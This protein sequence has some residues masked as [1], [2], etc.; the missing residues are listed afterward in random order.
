MTLPPS[1]AS[2]RL[3]V[4]DGALA[5]ITR[6]PLSGSQR[7]YVEGVLHPQ[8]KVPMR[9][10]S[11]SPTHH[12]NGSHTPNPPVVV[13]DTSG[14]YTDPACA[15]DLR[16]GL[17]PLRARWIEGRGDVERLPGLS[18][19]YGVARLADRRLDALR[20][21]HL[22]SPLRAKASGNVSQLHYAR[23][24]M[25][26]PEMEYVAIRESQRLE[27]AYQGQHAGESYG[28]QIGAPI[29]PEFVRDEIARGRAIIPANINHP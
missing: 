14:P 27:A 8:L 18:S 16:K 24:G 5:Q 13:Y 10:I 29:T 3:H 4:D 7:I 11:L 22:R 28:A 21:S 1:K 2:K 26:T 25:I 23:K 17:A 15:I 12:A 6:E 9:Q 20:F 19:A